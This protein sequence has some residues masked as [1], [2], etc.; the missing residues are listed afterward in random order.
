M[1]CILNALLLFLLQLYSLS[2]F[3]GLMHY[4]NLM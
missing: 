2:L 1:A 4:H 3:V